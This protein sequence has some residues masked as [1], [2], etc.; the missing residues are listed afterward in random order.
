MPATPLPL[1]GLSCFPAVCAPLVAREPGELAAEA[2]AVAAPAP[3]LLEW[4]VDFFSAIADTQ[5]VLAAARE[6]RAAAN[7]PILFTRRSS[8]E[9]GQPIALD[10]AQVLA[11][12]A[13]V[14][15]SG[16][17]D[18]LDFEMDRDRAHVDA[19]IAL[20]LPVV[21]S[22]HDFDATPSRMDLVARF[23][24]AA[25]LGGAVAKVAVMP[26]S[27]QDVVTV[28]D[29]TWQASQELAIP[30]VSMAMGPLGAVTRMCGGAFGSAMTFAVGQSASAPGQMPIADVKAAI[31]MLARAQRG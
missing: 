11:L 16:C 3:D 26:R 6:L 27:M 29:A 8:M 4:R 1:P 9:G 20:G 10:E 19:V 23:R 17:V 30:V 18:L 24:K 15:A 13:Q 2:R 12:Y 22:F 5:A 31:A 25:Q 7:L 14:A 28:L 21:L